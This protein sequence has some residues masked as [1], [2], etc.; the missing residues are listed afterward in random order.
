M[1]QRRRGEKIASNQRI[2]GSSEFVQ[3]LL[4]EVN[5]RE[6]ET[7]RLSRN[8]TDLL[9]LAIELDIKLKT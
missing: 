8:L 7:L 2:L 1:R 5:E 6:K 4:G 9:S 3:S